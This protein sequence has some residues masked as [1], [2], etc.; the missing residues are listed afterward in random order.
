MGSV[1]FIGNNNPDAKAGALC[2][3]VITNYFPCLE[4]FR[5]H[6]YTLRVIEL[7]INYPEW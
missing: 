3:D 1:S 7:C 6:Y 5:V 2:Y 4:A